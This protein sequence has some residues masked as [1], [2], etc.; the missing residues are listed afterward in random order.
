M[1]PLSGSCSTSLMA[2]LPCRFWILYRAYHDGHTFIVSLGATQHAVANATHLHHL[3]CVPAGL[4]S[5]SCS[6]FKLMFAMSSLLLCCSIAM[7]AI[8]CWACRA[9]AGTLQ[10]ATAAHCHGLC[11]CCS[12]VMPLTLSMS[13]MRNMPTTSMMTAM[14]RATTTAVEREAMTAQLSRMSRRARM[15]TT[16]HQSAVVLTRPQ[17]MPFLDV[18]LQG[19]CLASVS[20]NTFRARLCINNLRRSQQCSLNFLVT[21]KVIKWSAGTGVGLCKFSLTGSSRVVIIR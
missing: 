17:Q 2:S 8:L 21:A 13:F 18:W 1:P 11:P 12:M 7:L 20:I 4:V 16:E 3:G 5:T 6:S 9:A 15:K 14:R 10:H 19:A